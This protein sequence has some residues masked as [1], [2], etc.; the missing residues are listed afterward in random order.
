ML[1]KWCFPR[2]FTPLDS[3]KMIIVLRSTRVKVI[4][5]SHGMGELYLGTVVIHVGH[6]R[7]PWHTGWEEGC[8]NSI[9]CFY[10]P[11]W[12]S[13]ASSSTFPDPFLYLCLLFLGTAGNQNNFVGEPTC[14]HTHLTEKQSERYL[15]QSFLTHPW[16]SS[17]SAQAKTRGRTRSK[18]ARKLDALGHIVCLPPSLV[19]TSI[20][21]IL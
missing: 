16:F 12:H 1:S 4:Q 15:Q 6:T 7:V 17:D 19:A 5:L 8:R 18:D 20:G 11:L 14:L 9:C 13:K 10:L 21:I 2:Q 3:Q